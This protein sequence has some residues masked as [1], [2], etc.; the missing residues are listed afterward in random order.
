MFKKQNHGFLCFCPICRAKRK[1]SLFNNI[2]IS[3]LLLLVFYQSLLLIL[4][5]NHLHAFLLFILL[6]VLTFFLVRC[7]F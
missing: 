5:F 3:A 7:L 4:S 2:L 6:T 1:A